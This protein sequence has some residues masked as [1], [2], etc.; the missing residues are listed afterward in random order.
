MEEEEQADAAV[1]DVAA[2]SSERVLDELG[3]AFIHHNKSA[4]GL[5]KGDQGFPKLVS[6][7]MLFGVE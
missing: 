4:R 6:T 5:N 7:Q 2:C 1:C 3:E